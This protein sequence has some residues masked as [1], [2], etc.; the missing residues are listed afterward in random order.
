M[1]RLDL[2]LRWLVVLCFACCTVSSSDHADPMSETNPFKLQEDPLANITD[3]HAFVIDKSRKPVLDPAKLPDGAHLVISL[4]VRRRLLPDQAGSLTNV[5]AYSFRVHL[6]LSPTIRFHDPEKSAQE[7]AAVEAAIQAAQAQKSPDLD[8]LVIKRAALLERA[9]SERS[10]QALYGGLFDHPDRVAEDALLEFGLKFNSATNDAGVELVQSRFR[11]EGIAARPNFIPTEFS[12][13]SAPGAAPLP[14][15]DD[16]INILSGVFDDPFI[17]PRFFRGNVIGIVASIPLNKLLRPD[18]SPAVRGPILLWATTHKPDGEQSDYVGR[19][20]RTQLPRFGYLNALHPS[21]HVDA[22]MRVH[23]SPTLMENILATFI[24]PLIAHRHYDNAP[25]VM[26]YD[27]RKPARFPNGRWLEDDVA[28]LLADA[29]ETLLLELSYAESRQFPRA[30]QNDK[31]FQM[32]FPYLAPPWTSNEIAQA[33]MAGSQIGGFNVPRAQDKAAT[34]QPDLNLGVWRSLWLGLVILILVAASLAWCAA[35]AFVTRAVLV[36]GAILSLLLITPISAGNAPDNTPARLRQPQQKLLLTLAGAGLGAAFAL[37]A[38]YL[39]GVRRG[40]QIARN[41]SQ[42]SLLGDQSEDIADRQYTGTSFNDLKAAVFDEPYYGKAWGES[43]AAHL[44]D[45]PTNFAILARGFFSL[46]KR[47][48][49]ASAAQRTITSQADLRWGPNRRGVQRLLHPNGICLTGV[50]EISENTHYTGMFAMGS[51]GLILARYSTG[52]GVRRGQK[53]TFALVAKLYPNLD[54]ATPCKPAS[55]ITQADLGAAF[56]DSIYDV[57]L[58]NAPDISVLKRGFDIFSLLLI[59]FSLFRADRRATIRQLY[60]VAELNKSP[61]AKTRCPRF[62]RLRIAD[63]QPRIGGGDDTA[64]FREEVLAQIYDRGNP[65][66]QRELVFTIETSDDGRI[67][68]FLNK[69]LTG[70][71]F[72]RIGKIRFAD[73]AASY[74]GDFVIHFHHPPWREDPN[75]PMSGTG[76]S[77]FALWLNKAG[78]A[79][80]SLFRSLD[81]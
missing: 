81:R 37:A 15:Q 47:H 59:T 27:L 73:A 2:H 40:V 60:P 6:D 7:L 53:R 24:S 25:D 43:G 13:R 70:A 57:E 46:S 33:A 68:G 29:G 62:M 67:T 56:P 35:R 5:S 50:W 8:H 69:R 30:T 20:L 12:Q 77:K 49:L 17:F 63:D 74:H 21:R 28:K 11:V 3:L 58:R 4:C 22:I 71:H 75:D 19:S 79:L 45:Y 10:A 42:V 64:D 76:P 72:R 36:A 61:G 66:P 41:E 51:K 55:I 1:K 32:D 18:G 78:H 9:D 54:G 48:F 38:L 31:P 14:W 80:K 26:V 44:P 52:L 34:S 65:V 23:D 16:K 39:V